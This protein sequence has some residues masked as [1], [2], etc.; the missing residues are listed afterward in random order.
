VFDVF[1][2]QKQLVPAARPSGSEQGIGALIAALA[3]PH[4]DEIRTDALGNVICRK[5]GPGKKIMF[6]AHMDVIGFIAL[7]AD[8]SGNILV[9]KIGGQRAAQLNHVPVRFE[10]G[11]RGVVRRKAG[12]KAAS[13]M[14][15]SDLYI[16]I[17]AQSESE[18]MELVPVGTRAMFDTETELIAGGKLVTPYAD[19]LT[20]C[21]AQLMAMEMI[22]N[23]HNDL[24]FVFSV[25]EE[26]GCKGAGV[27]AFGI[28]PDLGVACDVC[29]CADDPAAKRDMVVEMGQGATIKIKD[30]GSI[31]TPEAV[32]FLRAAA[33]DA[34]ETWQDEILT[35]GGTDTRTIQLS[36]D[37]V[38]AACI[39]IPCRG[40]HSPSEMVAVS[41][42]ESAARLMAAAA[43]R[44]L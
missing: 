16:D 18:A 17:G 38:A 25:Q 40:I 22:K 20:A 42:V 21:A 37:G 35:G 33:R 36:R 26:V 28:A 5:A 41:D 19:D 12:D 8:K 39:S 10:N 27:A 24:Y 34:G 44:A 30:V 29:Y 43:A 6:S 32:E 7:K 3:K 2:L 4:C 23:N 1:E 11:V 9:D 13:A 31:G 14:G 15:M